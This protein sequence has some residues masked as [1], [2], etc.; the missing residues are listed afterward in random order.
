VRIAELAHAKGVRV[1]FFTLPSPLKQH[2]TSDEIRKLY[3]PYYTYNLE[4]FYLAYARYNETI[5]EVG[6]AHGV[7][8]IDLAAQFADKSYLFWDTSHPTCDGKQAIA[9]AIR[10][11][12]SSLGI[13]P[14]P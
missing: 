6:R 10:S 9:E 7:P 1:V 12:L 14:G 13:L 2:M 3:F 8:V 11:G 5:K 4:R